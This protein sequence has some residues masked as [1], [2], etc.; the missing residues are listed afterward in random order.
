MTEGKTKLEAFHAASALAEVLD[1]A[2][3]DCE[4]GTEERCPHRVATDDA[5]VAVER[6]REALQDSDEPRGYTL[7]DDEGSEEEV[8]AT[9][10]AAAVRQAREWVKDGC[11][12]TTD[13]PVHVH[14]WVQGEDG[15]EDRVTVTVEQDA[16]D[17]APGE[18]HDWRS[19]HEVVG[20]LEENPG[21]W[22]HGGGVVISECCMRCGCKRTTDTWAQDPQTG[23]QGLTAVTYEAGA[24]EEELSAARGAER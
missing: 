5:D 22:G 4:H 10:M 17:C 15:T 21:V 19:P 23:E 12:D 24:Y 13:G 8:T 14:V 1:Q 6:A 11:W 16:P 7:R 18:V 2:W 20:G 9:S 3:R